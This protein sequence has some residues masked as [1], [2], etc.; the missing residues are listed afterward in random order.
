MIKAMF[1]MLVAGLVVGCAV[2]SEEEQNTA[3]VLTVNSKSAEVEVPDWLTAAYLDLNK[4]GTIDI[5]DLVIHSKFF[6]QEVSEADAVAEVSD[7]DD[8][9][10]EIRKAEP[11]SNPKV[12]IVED[13][14]EFKKTFDAPNG[15]TYVYALVAVKKFRNQLTRD[16]PQAE[17]KKYN[18]PSCIAMRFTID[19]NLLPE[20]VKVKPVA[21]HE[22]MFSKTIT[23]PPINKGRGWNE[24]GGVWSAWIPSEQND[25]WHFLLLRDFGANTWMDY[26]V[27]IMKRQLKKGI[28]ISEHSVIHKFWFLATEGDSYETYYAWQIWAM[29]NPIPFEPSKMGHDDGVYVNMLPEEVRRRYFP[30]DIE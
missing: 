24:V 4:D 22:N 13:N 17:K 23:S 12:E 21:G 9:C 20:E 10:I 29:P 15:N 11:Y 18:T 19:E 30:E 2:G 3:G 5:K 8:P 7:E 25:D 26:D 27:K 14:T 16:P 28:P 6:G 1:G